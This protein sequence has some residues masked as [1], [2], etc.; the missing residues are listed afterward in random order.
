MVEVHSVKS[1]QPPAGI[2]GPAIP[3]IAPALANIPGQV[4]GQC[5]GRMPL[6]LKAGG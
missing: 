2:G 3:V 1:D 6:A 5:I 4:T